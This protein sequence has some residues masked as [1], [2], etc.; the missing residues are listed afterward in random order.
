MAALYNLLA[1][2]INDKYYKIP[3][4]CVIKYRSATD[5]N[6][7]REKVLTVKYVCKYM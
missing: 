6:A 5:R 7:N 2:T 3:K 1:C 4:Q